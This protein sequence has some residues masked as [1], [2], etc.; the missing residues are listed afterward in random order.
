MSNSI[1]LTKWLY[2]TVFITGAGVLILEV[3]AV[4]LLAPYFGSSL[5]VLS[6]VLSVILLALSFGYYIGGKIAD[7]YPYNLVLFTLIGTAGIVML[8]LLKVLML[9]LDESTDIFGLTYGP[10]IVSLLGFFIPA[11][12]LGIDSPFVSKLLTDKHTG[13]EGATVGTIFFF[14]TIGSIAGSL[15]AGFWLIP[16]F[17]ITNTVAGVSLILMIWAFI[18]SLTFH[19][20]NKTIII[21]LASILLFGLYLTTTINNHLGV[22]AN[23]KVIHEQDGL[24]SHLLVYE[25]MYNGITYRFL[26]NDTN[27]SSAINLHDDKIVFPYA[28]YATL[29]RAMLPNPKNYL[30]LGGGALTLP[31]Q[32]AADNQSLRVD[33]VEIEPYLEPIAYQ[34]FNYQKHDHLK[35]F[36]LDARTFLTSTSTLYDVI[37]SDVMNSGHFIPPHLM[38]QEF[39]VSLRER[40]NPDG[41]IMLN[42]IGSL[43]TYGQT[44]TG[45]L[46]RTIG[47]VFDN[48]K[49]V[50]INDPASKKMQNLLIV[51]RPN[52]L[53]IAFDD[54]IINQYFTNLSFDANSQFVDLEELQ[55]DD[56]LVFTDNQADVERLTAKQLRLHGGL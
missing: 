14:S 37:F 34:Y 54:A 40:T 33:A 23:I 35:T 13:N 51:I 49:I 7:R 45:S 30:V 41:I 26:K 39:F 52:I 3:S 55:L 9:T 2:C 22:D 44:L 16:N 8:C 10:L 29:Y 48:Y 56:E 11:L 21:Y 43:D 28:Q 19:N 32:V 47:T 17:G 31:R 25:K 20:K 36:N 12:L 27:Y 38:T 15:M 53:P 5:N 18:L 50:A 46:L 6:S 24:Y 42:Y 1:S 4:R